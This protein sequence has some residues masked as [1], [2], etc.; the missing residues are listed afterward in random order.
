MMSSIFDSIFREHENPV[1]TG[2]RFSGISLQHFFEN[3]I[4]PGI[5]EISVGTMP[6]SG[7]LAFPSIAQTVLFPAIGCRRNIVCSA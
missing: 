2:E 3:L 6:Y 7:S 1:Q 5:P 4:V